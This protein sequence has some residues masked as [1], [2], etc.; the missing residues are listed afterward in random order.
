MIAMPCL[1]V[2]VLLV[3][4]MVGKMKQVGRTETESSGEKRTI[5][6]EKKMMVR[7]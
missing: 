5:C 3:A 4:K 6:K 7:G 1:L 2:L